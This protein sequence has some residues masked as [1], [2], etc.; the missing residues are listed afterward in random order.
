MNLYPPSKLNIPVAVLRMCFRLMLSE[1]K[2]PVDALICHVLC[3]VFLVFAHVPFN[4]RYF[5]IDA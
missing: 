2:K 5:T 3:P 4:E 1:I